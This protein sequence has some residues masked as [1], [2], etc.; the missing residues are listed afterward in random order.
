MIYSLI[1]VFLNL[2]VC[3]S[4]FYFYFFSTIKFI[5]YNP[6]GYPSLFV[7]PD[8]LWSRH[9]THLLYPRWSPF[10]LPTTT[11][12]S[13][14]LIY[15]LHGTSLSLGP[16]FAWS[17]LTCPGEPLKVRCWISLVIILTLTIQIHTTMSITTSYLCWY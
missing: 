1:H 7:L 14:P 16:Y 3:L 9:I 5:S 6:L 17:S 10:T 11:Q 12:S 2:I 8:L 4:R 13:N 15:I